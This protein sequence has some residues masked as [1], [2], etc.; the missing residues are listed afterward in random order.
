M[1]DGCEEGKDNE[2]DLH[3]DGRCFV[4]YWVELQALYFMSCPL[5]KWASCQ[6]WFLETSSSYF[7]FGE[8]ALSYHGSPMMFE[9]SAPGFSTHWVWRMQLCDENRKS[10]SQ[11]KRC[12]D[13]T[14]LSAA[15]ANFIKWKAIGDHI[16]ICMTSSRVQHSWREFCEERLWRKISCGHIKT[17]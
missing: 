17:N 14:L 16:Q 9:G 8:S 4:A 7:S 15:L 3:R 11:F 6:E 2:F 12:K 1:G 13:L 10:P 5:M